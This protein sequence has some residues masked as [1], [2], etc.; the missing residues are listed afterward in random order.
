[1]DRYTHTYIHTHKWMDS[2]MDI[3]LLDVD[4]GKD[5]NKEKNGCKE[6]I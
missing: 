3:N 1:M 5:S 6:D 2:S 4:I